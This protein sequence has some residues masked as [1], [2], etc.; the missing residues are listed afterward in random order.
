MN[1]AKGR[2]LV[3]SDGIRA[4][5]RDATSIAEID[6]GDHGSVR[7]HGPRYHQPVPCAIYAVV[8]RGSRHG[9]SG[10]SIPIGRS[11]RAPEKRRSSCSSDLVDPDGDRERQVALGGVR[12]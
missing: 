6:R 10:T 7:N 4:F 3:S 1:D 9:N 2:A 8:G 12:C 5:E 11:A